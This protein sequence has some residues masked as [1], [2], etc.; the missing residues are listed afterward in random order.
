MI[1][2]FSGGRSKSGVP[3]P[4]P[5]PFANGGVR[6]EYGRRLD[7]AA[8]ARPMLSP[9]V[10]RKNGALAWVAPL[11]PKGVFGGSL[12]TYFCLAGQNRR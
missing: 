2:G 9:P 4:Y 12:G 8:A 10:L 3:V 11:D 6:I 1:A 7:V 5:S